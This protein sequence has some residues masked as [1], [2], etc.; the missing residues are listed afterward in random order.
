MR[1]KA[2]A[3]FQIGRWKAKFLIY[4]SCMMVSRIIDRRSSEEVSTVSGFAFHDR[5]SSSAIKEGD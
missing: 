5:M 1:I 2:A 3:V 4:M